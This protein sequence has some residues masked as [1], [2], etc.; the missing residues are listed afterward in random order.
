MPAPDSP[1]ANKV[2]EVGDFS[3]NEDEEND[4]SRN[5]VAVIIASTK[6]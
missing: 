5:K 2:G 6:V 4:E 1:E 3:A